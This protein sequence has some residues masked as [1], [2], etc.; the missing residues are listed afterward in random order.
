MVCWIDLLLDDLE[1]CDFLDRVLQCYL[2]MDNTTSN[3]EL[4][5]KYLKT[6]FLFGIVDD[7]SKL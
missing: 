3:T 6:W 1:Y 5:F 4:A 7:T 2:G